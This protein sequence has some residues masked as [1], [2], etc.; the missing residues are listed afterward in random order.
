MIGPTTGRGAKEMLAN[1][2]AG[3]DDWSAG[4]VLDPTRW[5]KVGHTGH[6]TT[7][8]LVLTAHFDT[9]ATAETR[10]VGEKIRTKHVACAA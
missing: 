5:T 4:L 9:C 8:R 1:G 10:T 6:H 3:V 7:I 2:L